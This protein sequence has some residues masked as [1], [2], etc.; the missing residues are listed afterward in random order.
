MTTHLVVYRPI[1]RGGVDVL[2]RFVS[3]KDDG[4][5]DAWTG[6]RSFALG[7]IGLFYFGQP[8]K[9]ITGVGVVASKPQ[10][11]KGP[12]HWTTRKVQTFCDFRP[13]WVLDNPVGLEEAARAAG[14]ASWY[15]GRPWR[16]TR[17]LDPEVADGLLAQVVRKNPSL[18]KV[19]T[20]IGLG[21]F[22]LSGSRDAKLDERRFIEGMVREITTELRYRDPRLRIEAM[23]HYGMACMVCGFNFEHTYGD[24]GTGYIEVHHRR[25]LSRR[26]KK[27]FRASV[28][29]VAVVCSNC[30]RILHRRGADPLPLDKIRRVVLNQRRRTYPA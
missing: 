19:L 20:K 25:P 18:R 7:E 17:K 11:K 5:L 16:S 26:S 10:D 27:G 3:A 9:A 1:S 14:L 2:E 24:L 6:N 29:D 23:H 8:L 21:P 12:F 22:P 15:K 13:V 28:R 30:H 4:R